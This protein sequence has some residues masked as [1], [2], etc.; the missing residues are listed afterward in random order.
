MALLSG[1]RADRVKIQCM[2]I[3]GFTASLA[4]VLL[5]SR[6]G[7][8]Q[9]DTARGLEFEVIAAVVIGGT[10]LYGGQGNILRTIIGVV[11]IALIRNFLN[12]SR[13]DIFWQDFATGAIIVAA[14]L[15]DALQKRIGQ[16]SRRGRHS[17]DPL[18]T[19]TLGRTGVAVSELG[20]GG[21]ASASCSQGQRGRRE[22]TLA[23]GLGR[24][25]PLFRHLA[26]VRPRPVASTASAASS[27]EG[28]ATTS[29]SRPRSAASSRRPP[30]PERFDARR[31]AGGLEFEHV[32]DYSYD[33]MMRSYEDSLQRLGMNRIDVLLIHDLDIW[34]IGSEAKVAR[35]SGAARYGGWRAL[36]S[37][38]AGVIGA[39]GAGI[40]ELGTIPRFLDLFDLDFFLVAMRY[41]LLEQDGARRASF[42]SASGAAS[43]SS[44]AASSVPASLATG[45]VPGAKYNYAEPTPEMLE[46]VR[47]IEAV[48]RRTACRWPRRRSSSRSAIRSSPR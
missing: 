36:R 41:T 48:C 33:G 30:N 9:A 28:R 14:V 12:L 17:M 20:F 16:R 1:I 6:I 10:S 3:V 45:A 13:I 34:H 24:R 46:R 25:H 18:A 5:L 7:A 40:N 2:V 26:L 22:A 11:I 47:R 44:S 21:A 32:F 29:C 43:A 35:L 27:T 37:S 15:L 23:G 31:L 38:A 42:R 39:I 4:G 8:I 19:R